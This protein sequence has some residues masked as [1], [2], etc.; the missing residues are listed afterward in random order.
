M[1]NLH[2]IFADTIKQ[3]FDNAQGRTDA[4]TIECTICR[5]E[6]PVEEYYREH[7]DSHPCE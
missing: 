1:S 6:V 3:Y 4:R 7:I 2:P 5:R